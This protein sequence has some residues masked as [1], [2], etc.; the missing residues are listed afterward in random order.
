MLSVKYENQAS[1]FL[2]KLG[3]KADIKRIIEG[4]E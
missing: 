1:K 3:V 4:F 2:K